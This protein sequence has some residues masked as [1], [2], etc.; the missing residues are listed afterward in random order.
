MKWCKT[1]NMLWQNS[2]SSALRSGV[3][4]QSSMGSQHNARD[5]YDILC[6][7]GPLKTFLSQMWTHGGEWPEV[8]SQ[9]IV[10]CLGMKGLCAGSPGAAVRG[11]FRVWFI[12]ESCV[13]IRSPASVAQS[14]V[15]SPTEEEPR[16]WS[17]SFFIFFYFEEGAKGWVVMEPGVYIWL[18]IIVY[19]GAALKGQQRKC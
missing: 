17:H 18:Y 11:S 14:A 4:F 5:E 10:G 16:N 7:S 8:P 19:T 1:T 15:Q 6:I 12:I 3:S 13:Y 2:S 9:C